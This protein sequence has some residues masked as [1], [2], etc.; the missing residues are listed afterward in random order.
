MDADAC[1][2]IGPDDVRAATLVPGDT[3]EDVLALL[4]DD[5]IDDELAATLALG[6]RALAARARLAATHTRIDGA[7]RGLEHAATSGQ[8]RED[9][10][11]ETGDEYDRKRDAR[12]HVL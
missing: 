8:R 7:I 5:A 6:Q 3:R 10:H 12:E 1:G 4:L 11:S 2:A 9:A